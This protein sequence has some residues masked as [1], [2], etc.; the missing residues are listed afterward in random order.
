MIGEQGFLSAIL[1]RPDDD[2]TKLVYADWLDE[3]G[4]SRGEYLRLMVKV[5]QE[6]IVTPAQRQRHEQLSAELAEVRAQARQAVQGGRDD[7]V[8]S[9]EREQRIEELEAR[10]VELSGQIRQRVPARLQELA[11]TLDPNWLALVSDPEIEGCGKGR[12]SPWELR[13]DFVCDRTWADLKPTGD[14]TVRHCDLCNQDVHFC[15]NL[16]DAREHSQGGHCIA[17]DLGIIR[18]NGDLEPPNVFLGRP[19]VESLRT[20]YEQGI[21]PVSRAR[22]NARKKTKNKRSRKR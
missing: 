2:T 14:D 22:L 1:E 19:S 11:A 21:D 12:P 20:T 4:D 6:R 16:A 17:V 8:E 9:A 7:D 5:R 10:L 3:Q 13:F 15:D 18:R